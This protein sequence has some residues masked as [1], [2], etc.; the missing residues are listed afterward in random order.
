MVRKRN[1]NVSSGDYVLHI[2]RP[3]SDRTYCGRRQTGLNRFGP[4][5]RKE[6]RCEDEA[7]RSCQAAETRQQEGLT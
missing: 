7:C 4:Q 2:D 5:V 6:D 1:T 3:G